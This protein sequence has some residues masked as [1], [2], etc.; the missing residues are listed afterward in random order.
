MDKVINTK[1]VEE[2]VEGLT[3]HQVMLPLSRSL[4]KILK[5]YLLIPSIDSVKSIVLVIRGFNLA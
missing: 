3:P 5:T 2:E 1:A 4:G